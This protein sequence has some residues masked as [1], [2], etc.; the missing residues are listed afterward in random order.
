[1]PRIFIIYRRDDNTGHLVGE[2]GM[3]D[4]E[5]IEAVIAGALE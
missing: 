1:M 2:P 5:I 3:S 4:D